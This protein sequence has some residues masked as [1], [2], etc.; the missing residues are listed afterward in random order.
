MTRSAVLAWA[1]RRPQTC[2][3]GCW[4]SSSPEPPHRATRGTACSR[5]AAGRSA[6]L[7]LWLVGGS[8]GRQL[9]QGP[10]VAV[11][12]AE[13]D[14]RAPRLLVDVAGLHAVREE[15]L[16]G[17]LGVGHH[18]LHALLRPRR[19]RSDPGAEDDGAR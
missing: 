1:S 17:R 4:R 8:P 15:L 6:D 10:G 13:G 11:G 5:L 16:P 3:S 2:A 19:H 9:L 18:A 14:E 7:G 12:V